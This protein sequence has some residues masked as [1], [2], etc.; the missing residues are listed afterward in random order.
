MT[1]YA[2]PSADL[3]I[4]P[5]SGHIGAEISASICATARARVLATIRS[6][7]LRWKVVFFRDQHLTTT[8]TGLRPPVRRARPRPTRLPPAFDDD[9]E[10]C[11]STTRP[12]ARAARR[13][14]TAWRRASGAAGTPTSPPAQPAVGSILRASS[15]R[16]TGATPSGPTSSPPTRACRS[17]CRRS[18]TGSAGCTASRR[19]A[20]PADRGLPAPA[21]AAAAAHR[22]SRSS[23]CIRRPGRRRCTSARRSSSTSTGSRRGRASCCSALL[24]AD[25]PAALHGPLQ[26]GA[27]LGRLLGQPGDVASRADRHRRPRVRSAAYRVTLVGDVPVGPDGR[28]SVALEGHGFDGVSA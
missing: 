15:S 10:I 4:R 14:P 3:D 2:P 11:S 20:A 28:P 16:P 6:A 26:V 13:Q 5:L 21:A 12:P 17:R 18:P 25:H 24:G 8:S 22:A 9:P 19:P 7:L 1:T 27:G 23:G